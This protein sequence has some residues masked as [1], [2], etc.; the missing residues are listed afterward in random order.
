MSNVK[1]R[2]ATTDDAERVW[3]WRNEPSVRAASRESE[4]IP[5]DDHKRW[6]E[7][8]L[9]ESDVMILIV[10]G[11]DGIDIGY[12]RFEIEAEEAE[13]SIALDPK[14]RGKGLGA[15]AIRSA[16][17]TLINTGRVRTI[18]ALIKPGNEASVRV[19]SKSGYD[20]VDGFDGNSDLIKMA[21]VSRR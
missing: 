21:C 7:R 3:N 5:L 11:E 9:Q 6:F 2:P 15:A 14:S 1:L 4:P 17:D 20:V 8:R 10:S 19:F 13:I 18:V 16:S 12:V